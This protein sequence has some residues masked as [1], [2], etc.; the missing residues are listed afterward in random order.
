MGAFLVSPPLWPLVIE[1]KNNLAVLDDR[2]ILVSLYFIVAPKKTSFSFSLTLTHSLLAHASAG[3]KELA[4]ISASWP[5]NREP[6]GMSVSWAHFDW[7]G[8]PS[9]C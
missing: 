2:D 3:L 9:P 5:H 1:S 6:C 4:L 7:G 8:R